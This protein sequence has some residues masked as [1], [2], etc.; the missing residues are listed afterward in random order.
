MN[1]H[2]QRIHVA[3]STRTSFILF[4]LCVNDDN[5]L[6][7]CKYEVQIEDKRESTGTNTS[8]SQPASMKD[9]SR[10]KY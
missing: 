3:V 6:C 5:N 2:F 10:T 9:I 7:V 4:R 1:K 8:M